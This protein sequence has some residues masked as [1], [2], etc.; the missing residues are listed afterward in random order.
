MLKV[1]FS[2]SA[3]VKVLNLFLMNPGG[4]Y[5]QRQVKELTRL[6]MMAVQRELKKL[7][8]IS[9]LRKRTDGNRVYY[10]VNRKFSILPELKNIIIKTVGLGDALKSRVVQARDVEVAFI[11]GSY[12]KNTEDAESD[13]DLFVIGGIISRRLSS[14]LSELKTNTNRE[15]NYALYSQKEF[16]EKAGKNHFV[17]SVLKEPKIFIKGGEDDIKR[18]AERRKA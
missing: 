9:L 10:Y 13:I 8:G 6:P 18:L 12:A 4:E 14:I 7:T 5:Y 11:Y 2:S 1:L 17:K 3:R 16:T 15:I